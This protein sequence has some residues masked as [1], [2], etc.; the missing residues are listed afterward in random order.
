MQKRQIMRIMNKM[1]SGIL[2]SRKL[3]R[4]SQSCGGMS[5]R[6]AFTLYTIWCIRVGL[7]NCLPMSLSGRLQTGTM[8]NRAGLDGAIHVGR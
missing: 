4:S 5:L 2:C 1:S 8:R 7:N 6:E 3:Q